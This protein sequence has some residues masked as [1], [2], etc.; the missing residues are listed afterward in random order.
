MIGSIWR[1]AHLSLAIFSFLF[2]I[3]VSSTGVILA[4]DAVNEKTAPYQVENF[5]QITVAQSIT[6]LRKVYPEILELNIDHNQFSTA[7]G[8]DASGSDFKFIVNPESGKILGKP[9]DKSEFIQWITALHRSL[10]IHET[11]RF[12][13]GIVSFLLF[14][15]TI[16]GTVLII[17]RQLG[18]RKFFSKIQK[19]FFSQY[20]HVASGR[21]LLIPILIISLTGTYLFLVRFDFL[22][23]VE[24]EEKIFESTTEKEI[25]TDQIPVFNEL[26]LADITKIEFPF[27]DDP[28]EYFKIKI[29]DREVQVNQITGEIVSETFYSSTTILE[30]LSLDL[31]TGR[32]NAI[33]AVILGIAS[34]NILVF[35]YSGFVITLKRKSVKIKNK[36]TSANAEIII[37]YGSENGSTTAFANKIHAQFLADNKKSYLA[38][39]D[40]YTV[41]PNAK[42]IL[43]LTSTYGLGEAPSNA[44]N[45]KKLIANHVQSQNINYAVVGFGS[46]KY[47]DYCA[48]AFE[49]D[50]LLQQ[51][52]WS[53]KTLDVYTVNN[54]S[55][56]AFISWIKEYN[57]ISANNLS[58]VA[59]TYQVKIP[60][61]SSFTVV[62]NMQQA[63]DTS[64]FEVSFKTNKKFQSG[65][66]LAIYP[67][68]DSRER[69]Y[70]IAKSNNKLTLLVK[71][72]P[73]G[74]GSTFLHQLQTTDKITARIIS[75]PHFHFPKKASSIIMIGN[76]TGIAPFL[77]MINENTC[78]KEM[79][80]FVGFRHR[81]QSVEKYEK[82][83]YKQQAKKQLSTFTFAFSRDEDSK[84]VM[85]IIREQTKLITE[86]LASGGVI[87]ICGSLAMQKD[88]EL[89]LEE[90]CLKQ[91][92][93]ELKYYKDQN[94]IKTDCY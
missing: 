68:N 1:F 70:S 88:V 21:L 80:L 83:L 58:L 6:G 76:G 19:D 31:H 87:M 84:Y 30:T 85:D 50:S 7:Q 22:S 27:S 17:K 93:R 62:D 90:I 54:K 28:D 78:Q 13:V 57:I 23:N 39:L 34:L 16:S 52:K 63:Q 72:H 12:I 73:N 47:T 14:L 60:K 48:F 33:W 94:Q 5:N 92:Q 86:K 26:K 2:L 43:I 40:Q 9:R 64:V 18:I 15:I 66:L 42:E 3:V 82:Y 36:F 79:H 10:F 46:T 41:F 4:I 20:L 25:A 45:A 29:K 37:L 11:G 59:A 69:L 49:I 38:S 67:A 74:L 35:I 71:L 32:T 8:F 65:D 24:K 61:L 91:N 44:K 56:I 51:Q 77:G 81:N 75:N 53:V 89:V 55:I